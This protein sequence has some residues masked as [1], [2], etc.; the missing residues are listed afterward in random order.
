[1]T[2]NRDLTAAYAAER[3]RWENPDGANVICELVLPDGN[4]VTAK[5]PEP[6]GGFR[7]GQSYVFRGRWK[8]YNNKTWGTSENQWHFTSCC[9]CQPSGR[10]GIVAYLQG[11]PGVGEKTAEKIFDALGADCMEVIRSGSTEHILHAAPI[12]GTAIKR[13]DVTIEEW[14]DYFR[15]RHAD[16]QIDIDLYNLLDGQG[17]PKSIH[18]KAKE[19]WGVAAAEIIKANP[20]RLMRFRGVGFK[21]CDRLYL[22][23]GNDPNSLR[24]QALCAWYGVE[25]QHQQT[26]DTWVR[27]EFAE[28]MVRHNI[29]G[30][31]L[32]IEK[33]LTLALR[34]GSLV[35]LRTDR[36]GELD[37]DGERSWLS[38][39]RKA[40]HESAVVRY[41]AEAMTDDPVIQ[42]WEMEAGELS[43][44]QQ[45]KMNALLNAGGCLRIFG[46]QPGSGKTFCLAH[47]VKQLSHFVGQ[48]KI[49]LAA[50]TGKAAVRLTEAL[51]EYGVKMHA[52]TW[53]SLLGILSSSGGDGWG[54]AYG[55]TSP[56]PFSVVIGDEMSMQDAQMCAAAMAARG[57]GTLFLLVGDVNQLPPVG[58]GAPLRDFIH[59]GVPY[60]ELTEVRRNS[61]AIVHACKVIREESKL[62][63]Q[64]DGNLELL[65]TRDGHLQLL[66]PTIDEMCDRFGLDPIWDVQVVTALNKS[67][68]L[69]RKA[70]N[71]VLQ[72]T[73]NSHPAIKGTPFR[74]GDK[75][76]CLKNTWAIESK[77][78]DLYTSPDAVRNKQGQ[79][80]VANGD[81]GRVEECEP[82][83]MVVKVMHP[84]RFV[85]VGR[86]QGQQDDPVNDD[87]ASE[88]EEE[89]TGTGCDWDL[90][91]ALSV[92]KSQG[93]EFPVAIVMADSSGGARRLCD[94]SWFYTA[95][96]R[97]KKHCVVIGMRDTIETMLRTNKIEERKTF[98][99]ERIQEEVRERL[100]KIASGAEVVS[101]PMEAEDAMMGL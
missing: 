72:P 88:K 14:Q 52:R 39:G 27:R 11:G 55:R 17:L 97:A 94:R 65:E 1:M 9:L 64:E 28:S 77:E 79:I 33:A 60:Q 80:Y 21:R 34:H 23:W 54:F 68:R 13:A 3:R 81:I 73:L 25:Y 59:A 100:Q 36:A 47:L 43:E 71:Q 12:I 22:T 85:I 99:A 30:T 56:L 18:R 90:A 26:G 70:I 8:Q 35:Q 89:S 31:E 53:H 41:A 20:Y 87:D 62:D 42:G 75:V 92:H 44:H 32:K 24:R 38:D 93:S 50:P 95:I 19:F 6:S 67:G 61:G 74:V 40:A 98:L 84:T 91:Y 76:V 37:W 58:H 16:E 57:K 4:T 83:R 49:A 48:E 101:A 96:S 63:I 69:S 82:R 5:G 2:Y 66:K 10:A 7:R 46:G 15:R 29:A 51:G 78:H 45:E 86:T